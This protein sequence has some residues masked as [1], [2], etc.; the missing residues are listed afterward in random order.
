MPTV[1]SRAIFIEL[2]FPGTGNF[3]EIYKEIILQTKG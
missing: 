1:N 2:A 3:S